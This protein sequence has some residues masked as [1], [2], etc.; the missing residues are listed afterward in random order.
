MPGSAPGYK[1]AI[2]ERCLRI[3]RKRVTLVEF[4]WN[5]YM[6]L[7]GME[8]GDNMAEQKYLD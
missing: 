2:I 5:F 1:A 7:L 4:I 6:F 8:Y 3:F